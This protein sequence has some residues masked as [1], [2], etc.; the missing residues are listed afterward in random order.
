[1]TKI[2]LCGLMSENDIEA[3][4]SLMPDYIG[5]V[6]AAKSRRCISAEKALD[7]RVSLADGI[8][9]VGVFTDEDP[10]VILRYINEGIID[11]AQLHGTEDEVYIKHLKECIKTRGKIQD[12]LCGKIRDKAG[13]DII[14]K[15]FRIHTKEDIKDAEASVADYILLDAGA[16]DGRTFDWSLLKEMKRPYFLAGGLNPK[17]AEDAIRRLNPF[18][19]D[20][21]SGIETDGIKD[22]DKMKAFTDAVRRIK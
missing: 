18:G 21:S 1:M 13:F 11:M 10:E 12:N 14:I 9:A 8:R 5:F 7:L 20:V 16:G 17:N 15:A 4:N 2:K 22:P 19:V 6:F 3:A